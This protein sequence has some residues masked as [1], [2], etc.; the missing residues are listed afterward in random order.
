M[1]AGGWLCVVCCVLYGVWLG[2]FVCGLFVVC[3][4]IVFVVCVLL[5]SWLVV[6]C[7][8]F[9]FVRRCALFAVGCS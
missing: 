9:V 7:V 3:W 2:L 1:F 8:V 4:L 5:V 6:S